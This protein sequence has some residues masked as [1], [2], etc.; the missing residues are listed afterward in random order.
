M[1]KKLFT[2]L[3]TLLSSVSVA[4]HGDVDLRNVDVQSRRRT[5]QVNLIDSTTIRR[6]PA[7]S[8]GELMEQLPAVEVRSRGA[9]GVQGDLSL[10]ASSCDQT[11]L[12]LNGVNM[13]DPHTG[14]Y[15]LDLPIEVACLRQ[16]RLLTT[17]PIARFGLA[18]FSGVVSVETQIADTLAPRVGL[19]LTAGSYGEAGV[20]LFLRQHTKGW[21]LMESIAY[22]RSDGH[23]HNTDY[24]VGNLFLQAYR[25]DR[26]GDSWNLQGGIQMKSYGANAFY[27]LSYPDQY[28]SVRTFFAAVQR[29]R[30]WQWGSWDWIVSDRTHTDRFELFREGKTTPPAWYTGHNY[31]LSNTLSANSILR[32]YHRNATTAIGLELRDEGVLSSQ[33]G[34]SLSH[35]IHIGYESGRHYFEYGKNRLNA[36]LFINHQIRLGRWDVEGSVAVNSNSMFG[37]DWGADFRGT[38]H[39]DEYLWF[40]AAIGR[41]L[42]LPTFTD[43][44]YHNAVQIGN[45]RLHPEEALASELGVDWHQG[46]WHLM[47]SLVRRDGH[48]IIDWL[49][50]TDSTVWH[51]DNLTTVT[52]N[53]IEV[54]IAFRPQRAIDEVRLD[55]TFYHIEKSSGE[56][57]SKYALDHLKHKLSLSAGHPVGPLRFGYWISLQQRNGSYTDAANNLVDYKPVLLCDARVTYPWQHMQASLSLLN[58][59]NRHYFDIGGIEQPG[60]QIRATLEFTL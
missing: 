20:G 36:N 12:L 27:S 39:V 43:L 19:R 44:Y 42:R 50:S 26:S 21:H 57:I 28:E 53:G 47:C 31:H 38:Y 16:I 33:L 1:K 2:I 8:V 60:F 45:D 56:Y 24:Q 15:T 30:E 51:C 55:Y 48:Q 49:R 25:E 6:S 58:I 52:M 3:L 17:S 40:Y 35:R 32:F 41:Y 13:N 22:D 9:H 11:Y 37:T 46:D 34:D 59:L 4:Q 18:A 29:H 10:R 14:H 5:V 54:G 23:I 7:V